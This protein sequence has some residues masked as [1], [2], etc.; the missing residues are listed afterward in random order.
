MSCFDD[1]E[2]YVSD[3]CSG[4]N[5]KSYEVC[6]VGRSIVFTF[7]DVFKKG[8]EFDRDVSALRDNLENKFKQFFVE[9]PIFEDEKITSDIDGSEHEYHLG[10]IEVMR[11]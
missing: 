6:Y 10:H 5:I 4:S 11:K 8:F 3:E 7:T 1:V 2:K 9:D